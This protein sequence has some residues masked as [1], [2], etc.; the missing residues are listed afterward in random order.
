MLKKIQHQHIRRYL[1]GITVYQLSSNI[2]YGLVRNFAKPSVMLLYMIGVRLCVLCQ[3]IK[4]VSAF[5]CV[6]TDITDISCSSPV[7]LK[8]QSHRT[9]DWVSE[10][11]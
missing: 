4:G 5:C 9:R 10:T 11:R 2:F 1:M 7:N 8:P 6:K 3:P